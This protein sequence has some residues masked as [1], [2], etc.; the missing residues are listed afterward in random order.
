MREDIY[1]VYGGSG[2]FS[3]S[4]AG[5]SYCDGSYRIKR[6]KSDTFVIEYVIEGSG[7]VIYDDRHFYP[8]KGD[9][10]MLR[11]GHSH[12]YFSDADTPWIKIWFNAAGTLIEALTDAY[13]LEDRVLFE[14]ADLLPEFESV[15]E[16][17][18]NG[19]SEDMCGGIAL[20]FHRMVQKLS[21][22]QAPA[23]ERPGEAALIHRYLDANVSEKIDIEKLSG[24]IYKSSSQTIR[25]FKREYGQ[26]PYEYLLG[27]RIALAQELLRNTNMLVKEVA[28][29]AGFSDEHYFSATFRRRTGFS[30]REYRLAPNRGE[31]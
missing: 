2:V 25:L 22:M 14:G 26:T 12:D 24:L 28:Y 30:P 4:L 5:I 20:I 18:K 10:Y 13:G 29:R 27:R 23:G 7:T 17:C 15:I 31:D 6:K 9:V 1:N 11:A 21:A 16:L 3:V 8:K 19:E